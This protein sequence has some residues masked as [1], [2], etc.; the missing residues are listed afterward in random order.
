MRTIDISGFGGGYEATCQAMLIAGITWL[1]EHPNFTFEGYKG[2]QNV[3]GIVIPPDTQLAKDL[4]DVLLKAA[5]DDTT[6][7]QHQAVIS[8]LAY[9]Q[10]HGYEKW[11]E[12]AR[13]DGG[14]EIIEVNETEV[15]EQVTKARLEWQQKL[16]SGYNP[17]AEM[18]KHIPKDHIIYIDPDNPK[19]VELAAKKTAGII[20]TEGD[21]S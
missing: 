7:A 14:R 21:A 3:T 12:D 10:A 5:Q 18:L 16:A 1:K 6:G 19:S 13:H 20:R 15:E 9:I 11:L 4:D 17:L 2:Y 8:H